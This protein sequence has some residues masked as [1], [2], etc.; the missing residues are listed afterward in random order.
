MER[1]KETHI[2][3]HTPNGNTD[4]LGFGQATPGNGSIVIGIV[5]L[6]IQLGNSNLLDVDLGEG[7]DGRRQIVAA[8]RGDVAL[9]ADAIDGGAGGA[10]FPDLLDHAP[11]ELGVVGLVEVVVVDVENGVGVG[12]AGG[13]EG[14]INKTLTHD[15]G[16]DGGAEGAV[17]VEHFVDYVL[18]FFMACQS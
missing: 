15:V 9:G 11:R 16:E 18:I 1:G 12:S 13:L 14:D 8:A 3:A 5:V 10:P 17:F 6:D 2:I 7:L 4:A